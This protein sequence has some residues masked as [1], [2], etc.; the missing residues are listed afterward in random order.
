MGAGAQAWTGA[1]RGVW[2]TPGFR[3][4][5]LG[6]ADHLAD[7]PRLRSW[8]R[9]HDLP[10][11]DSPESLSALDQVLNLFGNELVGA[12]D[13]GQPARN[14]LVIE[15]GIYLGTVIVRHDGARWR[16]W[17]NGHP[18]L[19]MPS[20]HDLDVVAAI[21]HASRSGKLTLARHYSDAMAGRLP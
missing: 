15:A 2:R 18:V 21:G 13:R 6:L 11:D 3:K 17:P 9:K 7:C 8:A 10:L 5:S 14:L 12:R 1:R 4:D 19:R 16:V 20:G